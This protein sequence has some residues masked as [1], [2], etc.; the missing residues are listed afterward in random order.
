MKEN[1]T[2]KQ[3]LEAAIEKLNGLEKVNEVSDKKKYFQYI[4]YFSSSLGYS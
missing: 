3:R 2:S 4:D 1:L